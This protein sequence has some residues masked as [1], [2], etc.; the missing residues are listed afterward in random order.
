M[1]VARALRLLAW[2]ALGFALAMGSAW[3]AVR[4]YVWPNLGQWRPAIEKRLTDVAGRPV[5]IGAISSGFDGLRPWLV[6]NDVAVFDADGNLAL[7]ASRVRAVLSLRAAVRGRFALALLE[8]NTPAVRVERIDA[9]HWRIGG[10]DIDFD[11][12][13]R[14]GALDRLFAH[15]KI[16]ALHAQV[17]W[18]DRVGGETARIDGVDLAIGSVGRQHRVSL[19]VPSLGDVA[20]RI[21]AALEFRR[22]PFIAPSDFSHW[23]GEA[24][25]GAQRVD[26]AALVGRWRNWEEA[27]LVGHAVPGSLAIDSGHAEMRAW[28]R[29]EPDGEPEAQV[30]V[31][32]ADLRVRHEDRAVPLASLRAE[33]IVRRD[34]AGRTTFVFPR[35][36]FDDGERTRLAGIEGEPMLQF[37]PDGHPLA[38]RLSVG[39]FEAQQTLDWLVRLPLPGELH[40]RLALLQVEGVVDRLALDWSTRDDDPKLELELAFDR[41]SFARRESAPPGPGELHL[42]GFSNV[43]G[44]ARLTRGGGR[45]LLH[46]DA[47]V[48]R[49]PG[50]FAEPAIPLDR[51]DAQA[52]W[53]IEPGSDAGAPARVDL[54]IDAFRFENRDASG[55]VSGRYRSGGKGAGI[56]DLKGGLVRADAARTARYLPLQ[57]PESV[58]DWV[59]EAI[60]E[61]RSGD[62][63]FVLRG[64]LADFPYR[65]P[66]SGTFGVEA[67]LADT[68]LRYAPGWPA[69]ERI[70]GVLRFERAAMTIEARSGAVWGVQLA[71]VRAHIDDFRDSLL[72]VQG[73]GTGP[74]QDLVR[75]VN[76]S[77]L[78][79][80]IDD[81]TR[82]TAIGGQ[83]ALQLALELP[84]RDLD[85][86]RVAGSVDFA[87]NDLTLDRTLPPFGAVSG[88][89]EFTE[90]RLALRGFRARFLGGDLRVDGEMPEPGRML[91]TA[92]GDTPAQGL[93]ELR[94]NE[95]TRALSGSARWRA[96]ADVR[97]R[98]STLT[99]ESD[100]VGLA[101]AL[102]APFAKSADEPW[103]LRI[104]SQPSQPA[105]RDERPAGDT[106]DVALR[107]DVRLVF[108]RERAPDSTQLL[109]RR[110]AFALGSEAVLPDAGFAAILRTPDVDLDAWSRLLGGD[111]ARQARQAPDADLASGFTWLP[112]TVS[113][114]S[115]QVHLAGK[116]LHDVVLGAT[117]ERASWRANVRA[118]GIDGYFHWRDP[119]GPDERGTLLARFTTL[120]IPGDRIDDFETLLDTTPDTLPALDVAA[121]NLV[122][123]ERALGEFELKARNTGNAAAPVWQLERLRIRNAAAL[124]DATGSWKTRPGVVQR[125]S[126]MDFHLEIADAGAL[127]SVFDFPD[128]LRGGAGAIDGQVRWEGSPMRLDSDTLAGELKLALGKGQFLKS[129]PGIAKLIGVVNLQ[130]LRRRLVFDFRDVF[131][132]GFAFDEIDGNVHVED[133]VART[134]DF[135]MRGVAAEVRIRG[136]ADVAAETQSLVVEVRPEL[137][138]GLASLAW[139]AVNPAFGLGSFVAQM[140]LR[141]PLQQ[142]FAYEYDV[143]GP[144]DDPQVARRERV[145]AIT[146]SPDVP[147]PGNP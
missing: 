119:A 106:L 46:G 92:Q 130:S 91:L 33:A 40:G 18:N 132:E 16:V 82:D 111:F 90:D 7:S 12:P 93:R 94:D 57:I 47:A 76:E 97:N 112:D 63:R 11:A 51:F 83:A 27:G 71:D 120:S 102:P 50:L 48:L 62:V 123:N 138:A 44:S 127:L 1:H 20:Q 114:V 147:G 61:G 36:E 137:N 145:P 108:E 28:A 37:S 133:G 13:G 60:V 3:L 67:Q 89:L 87:G 9:R 142:M 55:E 26:L 86:T 53:T 42:P 134:D 73:A 25:V 135:R 59:R 34:D 78:R 104:R 109:V 65:D 121:E 124:L 24:Y 95:L 110:A 79:A 100:L 32:A 43:S 29:F 80:R 144:W 122:L 66:S 146:V 30:Q 131:A 105:S 56:V 49:F 113:L 98:A 99:L 74:A 22:P 139:A 17:D 117:R 19:Q 84:L 69:I 70:R 23:H 68:T 64:D 21:E 88:R 75:F 38:A 125:T 140:V 6:A 115:A 58:R 85:G 5:T 4:H 136:E 52:S 39:R 118:R 10:F 8:V 72:H 126:A 2:C 141:E 35:L 128:V 14:G 15:R 31:D 107:D 81:F 41:L 96:T 129:E 103:P 116:T 101:S 45:A 143:S 54:S 77:A